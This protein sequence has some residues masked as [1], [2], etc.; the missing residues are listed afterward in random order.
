MNCNLLVVQPSIFDVLESTV[1]ARMVP[2]P[3]S[4]RMKR[5]RK[6]FA[7]RTFERYEAHCNQLIDELEE[8]EREVIEDYGRKH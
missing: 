8:L 3:E 5:Q 4:R 7:I 6:E 1:E 2:K